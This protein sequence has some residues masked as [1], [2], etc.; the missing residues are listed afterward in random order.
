ML[1]K[2]SPLLE[3]NKNL[4][5]KGGFWQDNL[6]FTIESKSW[7]FGKEIKPNIQLLTNKIGMRM[8]Y[9]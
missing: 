5:P 9:A 1:K 7:S 8:L 6:D 2:V 4:L 3:K